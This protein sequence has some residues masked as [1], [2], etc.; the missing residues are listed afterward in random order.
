L[1]LLDQKEAGKKILLISNSDW[2]YAAAMLSYAF[3]RFLP[4]GIT[5]RELF[6][7]II[8][9]ARKPNFFSYRMPVFR[10]VSEDGLLREHH[11][12]LQSGHAYLG[13]HAD[14][15][16]ESLGLTGEEI[17]YVG[18]HI[19]VDVNISKSIHR[20]R[21]ALVLRELEAEIAA[22]EEFEEQHDE[23]TRLMRM[24]EELEGQYRE[25]RLNVL[26]RMKGYLLDNSRSREDVEKS[27]SDLH[28]WLAALDSR[29]APLAKAS[30]RLV[31]PNWGS[32]M[33]MG[34]DKS[35]LARQVERYADIYMSRVSNFLHATPF[36]F[37]R[38]PRGSLPHDPH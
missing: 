1:T 28:G 8:V 18:D 19:F 14:L 7:I 22:F 11:G 21:T 5:W 9:G 12:Q 27:M 20:W 2:S 25:L 26:R 32:L 15:I 37:F 38:T 33:R 24:K 34:I 13:G 36:A 10:V 35:H 6:D 23:L 3:D 30:A 16:E 17:L 31:N 4:A 29:I